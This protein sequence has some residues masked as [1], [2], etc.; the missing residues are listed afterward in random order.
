VRSWNRKRSPAIASTTSD[1]APYDA[2][3]QHQVETR[4]KRLK[5]AAQAEAQAFVG[6]MQE[7]RFRAFVWRLL[8]R[9]H[10][11]EISADVTNP[12]QTYFREG[13]RNVGISLLGDVMRLCPA[14]YRTMADEAA[15]RTQELTNG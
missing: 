5:L 3:D 4:G 11:Y 8:E 13:E 2:G 15:K 9:C 12:Y 7:P 1:R 6:M 10:V 14:L